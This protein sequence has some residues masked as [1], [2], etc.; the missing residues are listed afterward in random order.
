MKESVLWANHA[1]QRA[2][3]NNIGCKEL[4][5]SWNRSI[6]QELSEE[7]RA[8]KFK[9]YGMKSLKDKYFWDSQNGLLFTVSVS[10]R[11]QWFI[12]TVTHG[13]GNWSV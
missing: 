11:G 4:F 2:A 12:Q 6:L 3:E 5:E 7:Q 9:R 13:R 8:Y 1:I 10:E